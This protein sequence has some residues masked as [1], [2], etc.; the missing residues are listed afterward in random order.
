MIGIIYEG[1]NKKIDLINHPNLILSGFNGLDQPTSETIASKNP[2][3][4][5]TQYQRSSIQDRLIS[6]TF[7]VY[8][9]ENT[10]YQL[11]DIFKSGEKGT[12]YLK[13]EFREGQI[14]CYF[15]E[16]PFDKFSN[17]TKCTIFL[18]ATN[19]Y[20]RGL[21]DII[22][23]LSNVINMFVLEAYIEEEGIVLG[24]VSEEHA[25]N[26]V[27]ESDTETGLTIEIT[28]LGIVTNP[29]IYNVTTNKFIGINRVFTKGEKLVISTITGKKKVYVEKDGV[30]TNLINRLMKNSSFF[31]LIRGSNK[32]KSDA[33]EGGTN[34]IVYINYRNEY[35]AI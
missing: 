15:E 6:L 19:P 22:T 12:L 27:N 24:E 1:N 10:R 33:T 23:E 18:R 30:Q 11:M 26:I 16:M 14:D 8:D 9:V 20:F 2:N 32:L 5:G 35:E 13:N 7:D 31:Q 25:S 21:E 28:M 17:P 3:K 4:K 34:M 29:I